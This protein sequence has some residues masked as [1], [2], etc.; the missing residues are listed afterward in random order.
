MA[1]RQNKSR[2]YD[3]ARYLDL[4]PKLFANGTVIFKHGSLVSIPVS[5]EQLV[6]E[7]VHWCGEA[8]IQDELVL[9]LP[10][11]FLYEYG[12][13]T[14]TA[15]ATMFSAMST[16]YEK[17]GVTYLH[18]SA[19][20][21]LTI[22]QVKEISLLAT[23][24]Y[25]LALDGQDYYGT[26]CGK[27][28]WISDQIVTCWGSSSNSSTAKSCRTNQKLLQ[29]LFSYALASANN[30]STNDVTVFG[31]PSDRYNY[32]L[33]EI[34]ALWQIDSRSAAIGLVHFSSILEDNRQRSV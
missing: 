3:G 2:I 4:R 6:S 11:I 32:P 30:P 24:G 21:G 28:N 5:L 22:A 13:A 1:V 12:S 20:S 33:N 7:A 17:Y 34:Q 31:P 16:I 27:T 26:F 14:E 15:T 9:L 25:L 10:S 19:V 23:G 18:C 29:D 8:S